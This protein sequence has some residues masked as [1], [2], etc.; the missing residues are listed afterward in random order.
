MFL[1]ENSLA[2]CALSTWKKNVSAA[3]EKS[4]EKKLEVLPGNR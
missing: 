4:M 2:D 1:V 3:A